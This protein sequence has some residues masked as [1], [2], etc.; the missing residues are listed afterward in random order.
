[1]KKIV[2][3]KTATTYYYLIT[4][5]TRS[6]YSTNRGPLLESHWGQDN[7][8]WNGYCPWEDSTLTG[9]RCPAGCVM[10]AT[11]QFAYYM[12]N[13]SRVN[14][15]IPVSASC[16][17]YAGSFTQTFSDTR[18][19]SYINEMPLNHYE[20]DT[21][22]IR[23]IRILLAYLGHRFTARY[24][25]NG[26]KANMS[27]IP[28]ILYEW[29][30]QTSYRSYNDSI[31]YNRIIKNTPIIAC[32]YDNTYGHAWVIDGYRK[33]NITRC[34]YYYVSEV[35]LSDSQIS[36]LT[37]ADWNGGYDEWESIS[38]NQEIYVSNQYY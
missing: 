27:I 3:T 26:T 18:S 8:Y 20:T 33:K 19:N 28:P 6:Y 10:V 25:I 16:S 31:V 14:I 24:S 12:R 32:G 2:E 5:T 38:N 7:N 4:F 22:K 15:S 30:L 29:G 11:G 9:R 23:H 21:S 36:N 35:E 17:G 13:R 37:M 1:M 34:N